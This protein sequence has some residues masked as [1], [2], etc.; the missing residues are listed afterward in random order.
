MMQ[1][2]EQDRAIA[3]PPQGFL[4][5]QDV[6]SQLPQLLAVRGS[7]SVRKDLAEPMRWIFNWHA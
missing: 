2:L 5:V 1:S 6:W 4:G 7:T 3:T